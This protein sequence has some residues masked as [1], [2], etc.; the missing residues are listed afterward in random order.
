[1]RRRGNQL[2]RAISKAKEMSIL[3][4][5]LRSRAN[6]CTRRLFGGMVLQYPL[7]HCSPW[8]VQ[9]L[10]KHVMK[11][12]LLTILNWKYGCICDVISV[13]AFGF[14]HRS[15]Q[16]KTDY[17][18]KVHDN[19]IQENKKKNE[20]YVRREVVYPPSCRISLK[21]EILSSNA[22]TIKGGDFEAERGIGK[23]GSWFSPNA[24]S[25]VVW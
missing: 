9:S 7:Q 6:C 2:M 14:W 16:N 25:P 4:R 5:L 11:L 23:H 8:R 22:G 12:L 17:L 13:Y 15:C 21:S 10:G 3:H 20:S 18:L 24:Y 1:M 19:L